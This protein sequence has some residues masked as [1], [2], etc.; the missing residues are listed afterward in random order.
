MLLLSA[1]ASAGD[2]IEDLNDSL[3]CLPHADGDLAVIDS[4]ADS[5]PKGRSTR[6]SDRRSHSEGEKAG[7]RMAAG[8]NQSK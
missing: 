7:D 1:A 6:R 2:D 8:T 5:D 3:E 4:T